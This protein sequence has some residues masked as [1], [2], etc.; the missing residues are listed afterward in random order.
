MTYI[1]K[2]FLGIGDEVLTSSNSF[3]GFYIIA[4]TSGADLKLIS[5]KDSN[6]FDME[7][8]ERAITPENKDHIFS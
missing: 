8:I 3:I 7:T 5:P 6:Q 1:A 2:A 4:K